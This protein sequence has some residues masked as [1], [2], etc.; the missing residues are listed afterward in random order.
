MRLLAALAVGAAAGS[1]SLV[2]SAA[3]GAIAPGSAWTPSAAGIPPG[4]ATA[5]LA[6][7]ILGAGACGSPG[8]CVEVGWDRTQAGTTNFEPVSEVFSAGRWDRLT[9]PL[10]PGAG[11]GSHETGVLRSVACPVSGTCVAVGSYTDG[12]G[13]QH[14]LIETLSGGAWTA[15]TAPEPAGAGVATLQYALLNAV[16]CPAT[17]V[18]TAVG[19]YRE[20]NTHSQGLIETLSGS[21]WTATGTAAPPGGGPAQNQ[22][23]EFNAVSCAAVGA[24]IAVGYYR[25]ATSDP[26]GLIETQAGGAWAPATAPE[27][28][29]AGSGVDQSAAL[30]GVSCPA[31][32]ACIATGTYADGTGHTRGLLETQSGGTW[33]AAGAPQ[34][35]DAGTGAK[36]TLQVV[37][38][39]CASVGECTA[40]GFFR[41]GAGGGHGLIE[42]LAGTTWTALDPPMPTG[43]ESGP[44]QTADLAGVSCPRAG[45]CVAVGTY[46]GSD[47]HIHGVIDT[48]SGL[49][50]TGAET[51]SLS[52]GA[53]TTRTDSLESVAC[54]GTGCVA[55]GEYVDTAK[56][57]PGLLESFNPAPAGYY[58][59][60][61]DGGIFAF[62]VPFHGSMGGKPLNAPIV[63]AA[64]DPLTGGYYEVASDGGIFAFTAPFH[65]SMGGK[66]LNEPIVGM[67]FDTRTGGY[68]E[69][70]SDG[71]L[72][73]FTAPFHGSMG[74][75]PL[76]EPI[77][78]MAFDPTTGGYWEVASDG[79]LFSFTA[80]F[81]GS[82]GGKPLVKPI[83]GMTYDTLTNGYYEVATDGGLFAFTAPFHG[84][85]GGKPLNEPVV[86][87][88]FDYG[89]GGYWEVASDGG[90]FSFTAPFLGSMGGKPLNEPI[91]TM[92]LG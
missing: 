13:M 24:C 73:A 72:F 32:G 14:G 56:G 29:N 8:Y 31:S 25:D 89:T 51:P 5:T 59:V 84:S 44:Q 92:A 49:S 2:W 50:W 64:A 1:S 68:Y 77:V 87:M 57:H 4:A 86:A 61:T 20:A 3:A 38:V 41:D 22:F 60:A 91:V 63:T 23:P 34:P 37:T 45:S 83:V 30:H 6:D 81:L 40:I 79:G 46:L 55:A 48:Q 12:V 65:G 21:A 18:C 28:S 11:T 9:V 70:A 42:Q 10:P 33:T 15:A 53:A 75:K 58:E 74:G 26:H 17:G 78:G 82:M 7:E 88:A 76:N 90:L 36:Q 19:Y 47:G 67:A 43:A 52:T 35:S 66:P 71:G 80:P 62:T 16:T 39:S 85:M 27:P 54:G 69:V